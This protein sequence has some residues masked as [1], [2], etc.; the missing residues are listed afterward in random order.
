MGDQV[1][2]L[3]VGPSMLLSKLMDEIRFVE[4]INESLTWDQERCSLSPG[5]RIKALILNI[6]C[7]GNPLYK[8]KEFYEKQD[9]EFLF[10]PDTTAEQFNDDALGRAL[11]Y[12]Y[13]ATPWK[14]Y[15]PVALSALNKLNITL[16]LLHNDTT[17]FSVYGEYTPKSETDPES[18]K[19]L[20]VTRGYSKDH[21]PDLKQIMLGM[22]V[23][24]ERIPLLARMENGNT[25][26]VKWNM[27]F[28]KKLRE[29]LTKEDWS[30]LLYQADSALVLKENLDGLADHK[31]DFLS[32][33]PDTFSLSSELKT[34]A[35]KEGNWVDVGN[36]SAKKDGAQYRYQAFECELEGRTYRFLVVHSDQLGKQ[37]AKRLES[38]VQKEH[39]HLAKSIEKLCTTPFHCREDAQEARED[40]EKKHKAKLHKYRLDVTASEETVKRSRRGRPKKEEQALTETVYRITLQSLQENHEE[41]EHRLR[42]MSTFILM[43]NRMDKSKL[44][45][46]DMLKCYKGQSA[47]ETRFRLLKEEQMI[48]AVFVKTPER[49]EALGIVY[50]MALLIYGMLEYRV[51]T[52]M[53]LQ[54][55]PLILK[56]N[57]KLF[58]PTG[59]A[60]LE[61]LQDIRFIVIRQGG[62]TLRYLPDNIGD[63]TKRIVSLAGYDMSIYVSKFQE[64]VKA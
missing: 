50:V 62:Q 31:L 17:S 44:P 42:L 36:L 18:E 49:I 40:F 7:Q 16:G 60:L 8:V 52:E 33:L 2:T 28:I 3:D 56:G 35:W 11:D 5:T 23:T 58:E 37:K 38:E 41:I 26:D 64:K 6:L 15:T 54:E 27:E 21:R 30:N 1:L 20:S 59:K 46:L 63:E 25:S 24:P 22:S 47:A 53:K 14:V 12:L 45:D 32:R 19:I 61:Q 10:G 34:N 43:T 9:I 13:E 29:V 51:R 55:K 48:D 39:K 57:R 4:I